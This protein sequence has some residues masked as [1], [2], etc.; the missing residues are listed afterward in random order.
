MQ[1]TLKPSAPSSSLLFP[2]VLPLPSPLPPLP[3]PSLP[4]HHL[5]K[6]NPAAGSKALHTSMSLDTSHVFKTYSN[7]SSAPSDVTVNLK[8]LK[9]LVGLCVELGA[10]V[11]LKFDEAGVPLLAMPHAAGVTVRCC[12]LDCWLCVG[13][14][15]KQCVCLEGVCASPACLPGLCHCTSCLSL[16][17]SHSSLVTLPCPLTLHRPPSHSTTHSPHNTNTNRLWTSRLS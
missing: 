2:S 9:A 16:F 7:S 5:P 15:V 13:R 11:G 17:P 1:P 3:N 10:D 8:D 6:N 4:P 14:C 12:W